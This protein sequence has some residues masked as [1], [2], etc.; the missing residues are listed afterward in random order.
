MDWVLQPLGNYAVGQAEVE[1]EK[2]LLESYGTEAVRK[3]CEQEVDEEA[4]W[5]RWKKFPQWDGAIK[6]HELVMVRVN[7]ELCGGVQ[8]AYH[9]DDELQVS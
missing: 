4:R 1:Q 2:L 8:V 6:V 3:D 7:E 9:A 5:E